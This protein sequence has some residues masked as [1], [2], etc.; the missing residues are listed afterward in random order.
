AQTIRTMHTSGASV[1]V[2]E[3]E[4]SLVFDKEEM[5]YLANQ[6]DIAILAMEHEMEVE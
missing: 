5:I 3:A 2:I 1:L 4:R 6:W